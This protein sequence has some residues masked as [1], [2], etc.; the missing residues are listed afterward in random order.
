MP[1]CPEFLNDTSR[2]PVVRSNRDPGSARDLQRTGGSDGRKIWVKSRTGEGSSF[3]LTSPR[4][5]PLP[6]IGSLPLLRF[7][8]IGGSPRN[9][10]F[11]QPSNGKGGAM[12]HVR[13]HFHFPALLSLSACRS[14]KK[15]YER[16][17]CD[18]AV[19]WLP[20]VQKNPMM[21][22]PL[23]CSCSAYRYAVDDHSGESPNL[24]RSQ[25]D[26]CWNR[27]TRNMPACSACLTSSIATLQSMKSSADGL[28]GCAVGI[29]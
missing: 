24:L 20:K 22:G 18:E 29:W 15:M 26:F 7:V 1:T 4:R 25:N 16:G 10:P 9:Q 5:K 21:P 19:N 13:H 12:K 8:I 11:P 6:S 28:R 14:A 17:N 3:G 27:L 2:Y 23:T